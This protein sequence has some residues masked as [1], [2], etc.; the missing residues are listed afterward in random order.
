MLYATKNDFLLFCEKMLLPLMPYCQNTRANCLQHEMLK[1]RN[2]QYFK[3]L[4]ERIQT[5]NNSI[6]TMLDEPINLTN[7][8]IHKRGLLGKKKV[9]FRSHVPTK[10]SR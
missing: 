2:T 1:P 9:C 10:P 7:Q 3:S 8:T 4:V 5:Q 6:Y